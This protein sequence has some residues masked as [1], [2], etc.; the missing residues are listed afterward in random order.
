MKYFK[1]NKIIIKLFVIIIF[2][3]VIVGVPI[4]KAETNDN[5]STNQQI[6]A[7]L[8]QLIVL[9]MQ[10][11]EEL[12][13]Q[14]VV[15]QQAINNLNN[16]V[17][18]STSTQSTTSASNSTTQQ[19]ASPYFVAEISSD[20]NA[21]KND[22]VDYAI[23][24]IKTKLS[25]GQILPNKEVEINGQIYI[26]NSEGVIIYKTTPTT[27]PATSGSST[28]G[29]LIFNTISIIITEDSNY[30][31]SKS[32]GIENVRPVLLPSPPPSFPLASC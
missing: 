21:V 9:L 17:F 26:S 10:Q 23:L 12:T 1:N 22:G 13:K 2:A 32:I 14:L 27:A 3:I 4:T 8:K 18:Q 19:L 5:S 16:A 11:V 24:T 30:N 7:L 28:C 6:I 15:Q 20:K 31:Y 25:S 29:D